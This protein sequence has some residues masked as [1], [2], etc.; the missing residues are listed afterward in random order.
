[1]FERMCARVA[2]SKMTTRSGDLSFT[3]SIGV[4][5]VAA[6]STVDDILETADKALYQAK[7]SG[8]NRVVAYDRLQI[9][10]FFKCIQTNNT[11]QNAIKDQTNG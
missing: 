7:N 5:C 1:M 8:R 2:G 6:D 11:H 4:V 10:S 9:E 3:V